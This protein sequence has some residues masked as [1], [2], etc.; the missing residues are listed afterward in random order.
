M[1]PKRPEPCELRAFFRISGTEGTKTG[2]A[3]S[4]LPGRLIG[5]GFSQR[6]PLLGLMYL[7]DHSKRLMVNIT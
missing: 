3:I 6:F 5:H 4:C 7:L 2:K 1:K